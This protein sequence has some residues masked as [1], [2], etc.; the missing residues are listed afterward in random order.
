MRAALYARYSSDLQNAASLQDQFASC[1]LFAERQGVEVVA[2]YQDAAISGAST[3][4]RPGL[5]ALMAGAETGEFDLVIC[6]A[7]DRL[8][9]SQADVAITFEDLR[10]HSVDICTIAE[11]K[12]SE[13]HVGLKGTMNALQLQEISRKTRRG[14][15]GVVRSGRHTGG[16]VYG[17]RVRRELDA[18][19][20]PLRGLRDI[21]EAE[22]DVVRDIY[23]SYA[24]GASPRAIV[25]E[26]NTRGIVGP[27]GGKWNASA[28]NGNEER[29]N[30]VIHNELY[31]GVLVFGRQT[32]VKDRRTGKR[33]ARTADVQDIVRSPVPDLRIIPEELWLKVRERYEE[34][35]LGPQ[36]KAARGSVRPTHLLS[37]KL[38][39]GICGGK[40]V[41]SGDDHRF[42][43][44]N[45]R[46]QG[47]SV[48]T[49][50]RGIKGRE[51]EARVLAAI[52]DRLLAPERVAIAVEEARRAA[53][54]DARTLALGRSKAEA[55][56]AEVKRRADRLV[57]EV[58][59]GVMTGLAV[60]DRLSM[61]E[62]RRSELQTE[63][64][65]APAVSIVALHP[66]MA[67]HYREVVASLERALERSESE[68]AMDAR[69]LVRR[70][71]E[72]VVVRPLP[73]R[74]AFA[75]TVQ[76][77]IA[78]LVDQDGDNTMKV[79]AGAGFEPATFRL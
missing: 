58:A 20:E 9:R 67:D 60:R 27:R 31:R 26:L 39:C 57:D 42:M 75:L 21:H 37:G 34:N 35:R 13:L 72:T 15:Q 28:I 53:E 66:R 62:T 43:C 32:W 2:S 10:F 44:S 71:I 55:E 18:A 48:C 36:K 40:L 19:G 77:K 52:K 7:L 76:G 51:I 22:A 69:D 6:E 29:G 4:N 50:G 38:T 61:L 64:A 5:Q 65:T 3:A 54:S 63:L 45:R 16:R 1:R 33:R 41:R 68:A 79:G 14:L 74:G 46:E 59:D 78:A 56:L 49:N 12:V 30:G 73:E 47:P 70:L 23:R 25:N 11:G 17:Y 8:P 24:A